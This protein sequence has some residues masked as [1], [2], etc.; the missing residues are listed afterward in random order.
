MVDGEHPDVSADSGTFSETEQEELVV[1]H[2]NLLEDMNGDDATEPGVTAVVFSGG[3]ILVIG[4]PGAGPAGKINYLDI[5]ADRLVVWT[6]GNA[7]QLVTNMNTQQGDD[8]G[9]TSAATR[10]MTLCRLP[11]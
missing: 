10:W 9:K 1:G 4:Q 11:D 6:R 8:S 7:Q 3:V 5:E 2:N